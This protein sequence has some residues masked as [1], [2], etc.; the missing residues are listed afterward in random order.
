MIIYKATNTINNKVYIGKTVKTFERRIDEHKRCSKKHK[1]TSIFYN[2][3][4]KYGFENFT[5][6]IVKACQNIDELNTCEKEYIVMFRNNSYNINSG[7]CGGDN[8]TFNP[9]KEQIRDKISLALKGRKVVFT[10]EHI[11]NLR[12]VA[13]KIQLFRVVLVHTVVIQL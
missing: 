5:W 3:I 11:M 2:A 8:F 13:R 1:H 12:K 9:N 10:E 4:N 7:G 6:E